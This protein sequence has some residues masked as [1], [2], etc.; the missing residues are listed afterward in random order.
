MNT[1][2]KFALLAGCLMFAGATLALAQATPPS[3]KYPSR[4]GRGLGRM[5]SDHLQCRAWA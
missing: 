2:A 1:V 5:R 4:T 3:H